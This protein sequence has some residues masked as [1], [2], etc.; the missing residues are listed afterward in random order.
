MANFAEDKS[1][2]GVCG[3][4]F[5]WVATA[6]PAQHVVWWVSQNGDPSLVDLPVAAGGSVRSF[7][8]VG[9]GKALASASVG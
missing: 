8:G 2:T 5:V 4:V 7:R 1:P 6:K 9:N 3:R